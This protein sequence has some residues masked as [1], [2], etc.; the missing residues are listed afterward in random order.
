MKVF[1]FRKIVVPLMTV[2]LMLVFGVNL[3]GVSA[4]PQ[5]NKT[6]V[7]RIIHYMG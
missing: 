7:I 4:A 6:Q 3:T 5:S 2:V 1:K